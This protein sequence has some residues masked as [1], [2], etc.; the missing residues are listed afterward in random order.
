MGRLMEDTIQ[1]RWQDV[2]GLH[3]RE[4]F[5]KKGSESCH[6][7]KGLWLGSL[8]VSVTVTMFYCA[9]STHS[10]KRVL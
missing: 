1:Q 7:Y 3:E 4:R 2:V 10:K 6:V 9:L 8:K 5:R